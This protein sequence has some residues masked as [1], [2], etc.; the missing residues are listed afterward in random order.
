MTN[1]ADEKQI[2]KWGGNAFLAYITV[3]FV[4]AFIVIPLHELM[5]AVGAWIEGGVVTNVVFLDVQAFINQFFFFMPSN[6]PLGQVFA[7]NVSGFAGLPAGLIFYG[8]PYIVSF[9]VGS[10]LVLGDNVNLP[11]WVRI[12]GAPLIYYNAFA[13]PYEY[14]LYAGTD[15]MTVNPFIMNAIYIS[16]VMIGITATSIESLFEP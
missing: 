1:Y 4:T 15:P 7:D 8:L 3:P 2:I 10:V 12:I 16:V 13:L 5:H 6:E 14:S 9:G 11:N